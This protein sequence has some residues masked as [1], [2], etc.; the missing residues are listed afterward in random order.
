MPNSLENIG[1]YAFFECE[2]LPIPPLPSSLIIIGDCAFGY[3]GTPYSESQDLIIPDLVTS[4]GAAA[5]YGRKLKSIILGHSL[6][7]IGEN[8]FYGIGNKLDEIR[9]PRS[10]TSIGACAFFSNS[11]NYP[12][13]VIV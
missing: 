6:E 5:F 10:V 11:N 2:K 8:A 3:M 7:N 13:R 12:S 4:I 9:I 1:G